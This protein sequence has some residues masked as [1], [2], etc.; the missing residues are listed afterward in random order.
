MQRIIQDRSEE[1]AHLWRFLF[2]QIHA[3]HHLPRIPG[4]NKEPES[5][6]EIF[7]DHKLC[8]LNGVKFKDRNFV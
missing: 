8:V 7:W 3:P 5:Q 4:H 1:S 6:A 2:L